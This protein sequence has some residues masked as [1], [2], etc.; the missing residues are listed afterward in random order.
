MNEYNK[1]I[2]RV[3]KLGV[4]PLPHADARAI[5]KAALGCR[6][7]KDIYRQYESLLEAGRFQTGAAPAGSLEEDRAA[8]LIQAAYHW[9]AA[10]QVQSGQPYPSA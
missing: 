1:Y 7:V 8:E 6:R 3:R 10:Y 2:S 9:L 4:T 5:W